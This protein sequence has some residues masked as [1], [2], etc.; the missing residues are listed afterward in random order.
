MSVAVSLKLDQ[1]IFEDVNQII[2]QLDTSRN[3]YINEA[4]SYYNKMQKKNA[5]QEQ[6]KIELALIKESSMEVL[7]EMEALPDDYETI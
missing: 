4:L 6:L 3:K 5:I 1:Q 2:K 7:R